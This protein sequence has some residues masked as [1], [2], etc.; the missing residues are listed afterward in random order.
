[1]SPSIARSFPV[2]FAACPVPLGANAYSLNATLV[3][4]APVGFLTLGNT[5]SPSSSTLN[6]FDGTV[7][8]NAAIV[9]ATPDGSV[10]AYAS[11]ATQ[12][13]R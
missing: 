11:N 4:P 7:A 3:P 1:M 12:L 6:D 5:P 2:P 8:S 13:I 10:Y 9:P